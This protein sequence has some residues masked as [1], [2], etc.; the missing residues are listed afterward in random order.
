MCAADVVEHLVG[1]CL[2]A[3]LDAC[4]RAVGT[5][6]PQRTAPAAVLQRFIRMVLQR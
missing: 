4:C 1:S 2:E 5:T 3:R 6:R